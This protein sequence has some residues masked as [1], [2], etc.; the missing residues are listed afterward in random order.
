M[1]GK[2]ICCIALAL[3]GISCRRPVDSRKGRLMQQIYESQKN[4]YNSISYQSD[5]KVIVDFGNK[6]REILYRHNGIEPWAL[7]DFIIL[8]GFAAGWGD[9]RGL[10]ISESGHYFYSN[11]VKGTMVFTKVDNEEMDK[12]SGFGKNIIERVQS[13]D[14]AYINYKNRQMGGVN[15]GFVFIATRVRQPN[16]Q[17]AK[18]SSIAFDQFPE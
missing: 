10:L 3:F 7:Q 16:G 5:Y 4:C 8:E 15:D 18:I 14:T 1:M 17:P 2:W 12:K 9:Y 13:W 11:K 6:R